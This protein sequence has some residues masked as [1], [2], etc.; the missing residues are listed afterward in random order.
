VDLQLKSK[1]AIV[2]GGS[3]GI[4]LAIA[5]VLLAE[6]ADVAVASRGAEAREKAAAE[7]ASVATGRVLPVEVD[8]ADDGSVRAM[9]AAVV[10]AFGG[11]DILVNAAAV[12]RSG[13]TLATATDADILDDFNVKVVGYLRTAR[14]AAPHMA[15]QGW[16]RII[17]V[18]G[19][20]ARQS[21]S[22]I[23]SIR[24]I[25]VAALSKNLA[26]E[27]GPQGINVTTVSPGAT[28]TERTASML[29]ERA[30]T[31]GSSVDEVERA[32]AANVSIGRIV[33]AEEVGWV[34]AFLASPRS[35]AING[36]T[37]A[38]GG[39]SKGAIHP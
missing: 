16:G 13:S 5:R 36:D 2:T 14:H 3:K 28:R 22:V 4:G 25:G 19:L 8:T 17:N 34:V 18:S 29:A 21:G 10:A 24:N 37:V 38:V 11:V 1:R 39:G 9:V 6:G 12:P 35:V 30:R 20:S 7:L 27:L 32:M 26:D 31:L 15:A 23:G 33:D